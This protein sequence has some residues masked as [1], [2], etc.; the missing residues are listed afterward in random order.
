[1]GRI[2]GEIEELM[3][4]GKFP[5]GLVLSDVRNARLPLLTPKLIK[6]MF[7][8][9]IK[10]IWEWLL[11][12]KVCRIGVY[13]MGGVGKTT[14]MMQVHNMLL[15]GQIMFRD[16]YW[17]TITHSSTN[18]L[19]NKIAKAVGLDLRNEEDCRRRAATLSNMLSKIGKKLLILDDMWQHF[20]LDEVGIPLAGNSCKIIITTRSLDV[21]RRM[22]CQQ[23]LKVEPLPEREAWTLFLENLGNYEGLPME[24]M[25]IA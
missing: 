14:I 19:Q 17:V 7:E 8:Q 13:G 16:V 25:K 23:I 3:Q 9:H 1:M 15:E 12:D 2:S 21:C 11:D 20:P 18:E 24:S 10:T 5:N 6:Q 4:Q 22:S